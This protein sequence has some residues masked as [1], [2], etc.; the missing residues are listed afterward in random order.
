MIRSGFV[1]LL[2]FHILLFAGVLPQNNPAETRINRASNFHGSIPTKSPEPTIF[3]GQSI[4]KKLEGRAQDIYRF[5]V[6]RGYVARFDVIQRGV[7]VVINIRSI[8]GKILKS[9]DRPSGSFGRESVTLISDFDG[10]AIFEV[11]AYI[12]ETA[13]GSYELVFKESRKSNFTDEL[14]SRA[15]DLTSAAELARGQRPVEK[16]REAIKNFSEAIELWSQL[17]DKYEQA[18]TLYGIGFT[19]Y[20]LNEFFEAATRYQSALQL[21]I[22]LGDEFGQAVNHSALGAVQYSLGEVTLASFN[23]RRAIDIY[24]K[25]DNSRGLGISFH[26]LGTTQLLAGNFSAAKTEL[27]ESYRWRMKANDQSGRL[28]TGFSLINLYLL[29]GDKDQATV[30]L[31]ELEN[32]LSLGRAAQNSEYFYFSGRVSNARN[33][34]LLAEDVLRKAV[35]NFTSEGN[36]LRVAQSMFELSRAY[37]GLGK[38][39]EADDTIRNAITIVEDLRQATPNLSARVNF[40]SLIQPFFAHQLQVLSGLWKKTSDKR[41]IDRAFEIAERSRSRGLADQL[42]RKNLLKDSKIDPRLLS[43]EA[44]LR[45][46]IAELIEA[47]FQN[48]EQRLERL[49][50]TSAEY[51]AL[52]ARINSLL[53]SP[54][55]ESF[56][57]TNIKEIQSILRDDKVLLSISAV[58]SEVLVWLITKNELNFFVAGKVDELSQTVAKTFDCL[59]IRPSAGNSDCNELNSSL[60]QVL[61]APIEE[62]IKGKRLVVIKDGIFEKIPFQALRIPSNN[63]YLLEDN[64]IVSIPSAS[65]FKLMERSRPQKKTSGRIAVFADPVYQATDER[66]SIK[67]GN[68]PIQNDLELPRLFASRFEANRINSYRSSEVDL[69]LDFRATTETL[70]KLKLDDYSILHFATHTLI[71]D[72]N[73]ELSAVVLSSFSES[74]KRIKSNLRLNELQRFDLD[75]DLVFLSACQT[76]F[77]KQVIGEGFISLGQS[78][79]ASGAR[80]VVFTGWKIDDRVTAELVSRFYKK[81]LTEESDAPSSLREAQLSIFRDRRTRH[82]F[83]WAGFAVQSVFK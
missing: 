31:R 46:Q 82:P 80:S 47:S 29:T 51:I 32:I 6:R 8:D 26:G 58:S 4:R 75:A 62:R 3:V 61:L 13:D 7:D 37:E 16:K 17:D 28:L 72:R 77:G 81:Y 60:G 79:Y 43:R 41:F 40:T 45:D 65:L 73:P 71:N 78:F 15:E 63:R 55:R 67:F 2:L 20:S 54:Q 35:S 30:Q 5:D 22:S 49:Q 76:G 69:F 36:R 23:Y 66:F 27:E 1:T 39:E 19:H 42:E 56:S 83:Y 70:E 21:M 64:E 9:T 11:S 50:D 25:L 48:E 33:Q 44:E 68:L 38:L 53:D 18:V 74:G 57:I 59:S 24:R 10:V 12:P 34:Y 14:R 52:E